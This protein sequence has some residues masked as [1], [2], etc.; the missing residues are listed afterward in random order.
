MDKKKNKQQLIYGRN[1]IIEALQEG[2]SFERIYI[3]DTLRGE[4]EKEVRHLCNLHKI[5]L[6]RVPA[7]KLDKLTYHK[8]HQGIAGLASLIKYAS[9]E[10]IV[11]FIFEQGESPLLLILENI[12][13]IRNVGAISRTAEAFGVHCL[14]LSGGNSA[15]VNSEAV[16]SSAGSLL[17]IPVCRVHS[18]EDLIRLLGDMGI[19]V[20]GTSSSAD[21]PLFEAD[22]TKP[23]A[24]LLGSEGGGLSASVEDLC[25]TLVKI[26]IQGIT[27]SLN[28]S[29]ATGII[30]YEITNQSAT[31]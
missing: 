19:R 18:T 29:V 6:K 7:V 15:T 22:M 23:V 28:V 9:I 17:R 31:R 16:K 30:L 3:R 5:P 1:T 14:I 25:H 24:I 2:Q 26:P 12:Q 10:N 8:N 4:F 13:D 11:P 20:V 27:E 21:K